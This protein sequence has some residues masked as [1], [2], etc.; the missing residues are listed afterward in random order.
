VI[1]Q[2]RTEEPLGALAKRLV[3][4]MNTLARD[5]VDLA[6][7][8]LGHE[9]KKAAADAAGLFVGAMVL[10]VGFAMLCAALVPALASVVDPLWLRMVIAA[11]AFL[12]IGGVI[13]GSLLARLKKD[14]SPAM[15]H[16]KLEARETG[17]LLKEQVQ[18]G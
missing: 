18:H 14:L 7:V 8:E 5:H 17:H 11:G 6:R 3:E 10:V 15:P 4:D 16:A 2:E 12:V 13:A 1:V 9:L